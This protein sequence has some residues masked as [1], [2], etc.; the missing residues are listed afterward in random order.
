M[1]EPGDCEKSTGCVHK[2]ISSFAD[3]SSLRA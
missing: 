3:A 2:P 1:S